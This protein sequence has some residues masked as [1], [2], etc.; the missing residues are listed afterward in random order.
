MND[1]RIIFDVVDPDPDRPLTSWALKLLLKVLN[2]FLI[3]SS[4]PEEYVD[5]KWTFIN[6]K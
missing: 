6:G 5:F 4:S 1:R 2:Q 3:T